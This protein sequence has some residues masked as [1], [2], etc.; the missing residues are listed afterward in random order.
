ML[1]V[2]IYHFKGLKIF[3]TRME[4]RYNFIQNPLGTIRNETRGS[5]SY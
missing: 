3:Y 1:S 2:G 4:Y 5:I